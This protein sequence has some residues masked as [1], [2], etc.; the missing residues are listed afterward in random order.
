MTEPREIPTEGELKVAGALNVLDSQGHE[1]AF[2]SLFADQKT[3]VA[4]IRH[5]GCGVCTSP[6]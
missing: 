1:V 3:I 6:P 2:S 5:F 4:F